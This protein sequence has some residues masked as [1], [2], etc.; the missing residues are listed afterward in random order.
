MNQMKCSKDDAPAELDAT[1]WDDLWKSNTTGWDLKDASPALTAY[2]DTF[3]CKNKSILIPGCGNAYEVIYL[4]Q[5]GFKNIT[6]I[7]ISATLVQ[8]LLT[9]FEKN[10]GKELTI[11]CG[12]F[13]KHTG[14]YDFIIEQTFFC[15]LPKN[16]RSDYAQKMQNLLKKDGILAGLLFNIEFEKNPPFGG[17]KEEYIALFEPLFTINKMEITTQS[18]QPRMGSELFFELIKKEVA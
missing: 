5:Q 8:S 2:F 18:V 17:N 15:A 10:V 16:R 14:Q 11:I 4:L 9:K 6:I 12:D 7:D 3:S 1:F 13:F